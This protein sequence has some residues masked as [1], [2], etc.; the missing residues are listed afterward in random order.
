MANELQGSFTTGKVAYFL[1]RDRNAQ[2]WSTVNG[3]LGTYNSSNYSGYVISAAEQGTASSFYI[4]NFPATAG[5]GD[6]GVIM[7]QQLGSNPAETDPTVDVGT[8]P[9][10]GVNVAQ[11]SDLQVSGV[12]LSPIM[13]P[14]SFMVQNFPI[15]FRSSADH[16]TPFTSGVVS[17]Q[18]SRDGGAFGPLQSGAFTEVGHGFFNL[19]ALTSG[20]LNANTISLLFTANGISGG[21]ADPVPQSFFLKRISGH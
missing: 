16:L 6:Y 21:S 10:N 11:L 15:Y 3:S 14:R 7:K 1:I 17:G 4:G 12:A 2:I 8:V 20:D 9:W 13:L 19:Q 18:I 5:P